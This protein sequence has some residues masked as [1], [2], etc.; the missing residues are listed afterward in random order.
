MTSTNDSLADVSLS[1]LDGDAEDSENDATPSIGDKTYCRICLRCRLLDLGYVGYHDSPDYGSNNYFITRD[2]SSIAESA[3]NCE[4]CLRII[5]IVEEWKN[6]LPATDGDELD[7]PR[8]SV[9]IR[10]ETDWHDV[11]TPHK[12]LRNHAHSDRVRIGVSIPLAY[13]ERSTRHITIFLQRAPDTDNAG[14]SEVPKM[15]SRSRPLVASPLLLKKWKQTCDT[16]HGG[17]CRTVFKATERVRPRLI[18]VQQ[19]CLVDAAEHDQWVC[20]SY[21]WGR[22]ETLRLTRQNV[23]SLYEPGALTSR[24]LPNVVEDALQ[25]TLALGEQFL[26]V[27]ALCIVQ[28]DDNDKA[29][30]I[31]RMDAIYILAS[32]VIVAATCIDSN[33]YLPGVRAN[34]RWQTPKPF[35]IQG[36]RLVQCLDPADGVMIDLRNGRS[37]GYLGTTVWDTR[38]WT[39]QERFLASRCLVFTPE[40]IFWE[41]ESGFWCED[42]HREVPEILPDPRR[43]SLCGGELDIVWNTDD[44]AFDHYYR[45]L[46][47]EYSRR[48]MS[49]EIDGLNAFL[50]VVRAFET[51]IKESF[52]WGMP[53]AYLESALAWGHPSPKLRRR[54][55]CFPSWSW[56]G[57]VDE[58]NAKIQNQNL[59]MEPL[60][61]QFFKIDTARQEL[62]PLEQKMTPSLL[63]DLLVEGSGIPRREERPTQIRFEDVAEHTLTY[64]QPQLFLC[65]WTASAVL[66]VREPPQS[67]AAAAAATTNNQTTRPHTNDRW[68]T[69]IFQGP[70]AINLSWAQAPN[71]PPPSQ[72]HTHNKI[73][74]IAIAQNRGLWDGGHTANGAIGVMLLSPPQAQPAVGIGTS[75]TVG[76]AAAATAAE[77]CGFAW[78]AIRDWIGISAKRWEL[79][80]LV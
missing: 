33:S 45:K 1:S 77:R 12:T 74:V 62:V 48:A 29:K 58:G 78:M 57:W 63:H 53:T 61:L 36:V 39:L 41:C 27:D 46:L 18:N 56:C 51:S 60:G 66:E 71:T 49:Q 52:F 38:A 22:A 32:V 7:L 6:Q 10:L 34:T 31:A 3:Q 73:K 17:K 40:Q 70:T 23:T 16:H 5:S 43:T 19:R 67:A 79:V 14:D 11:R 44:P 72:P 68:P 9:D 65:F 20:L 35:S 76:V 8:A 80:V 55:G 4:F 37:L 75:R 25:V 42:S 54:R 28:D 26:W 69:T 15:L 13:I 64:P 59:Q 21:V 50:G 2:Y 30:F 47:E 24:L